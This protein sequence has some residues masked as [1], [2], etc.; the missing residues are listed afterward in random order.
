MKPYRVIVHA[1]H[2]APKRRVESAAPA[3]VARPEPP[4]EPTLAELAANFGAAMARVVASAAAGGRVKVTEEEYR[5]R[6]RQCDHCEF[7]DPAWFGIGRCRA[8]GCGCT[9]LKRYLA[10]EVCKHPAGSRW[11]LLT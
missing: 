1:P 11:P 6:S 7:W 2:L 4:Y 8:P 5:A 3:P 9:R 10:T